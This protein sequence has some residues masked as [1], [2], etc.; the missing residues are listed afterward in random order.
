MR[1]IHKIPKYLLLFLVFIIFF[2]PASAFSQEKPIAKLADFSGTVLIKSQGSWGVKPVKDLPL[3]SM[4]KLVTRV[5]NATIVFNDGGTINIKNNTNLLINEQEKK[6]GLVTIIERHIMLFLG[7]LNFKTGKSGKSNVE[8][9][10]ETTRA[11]IGIRGTAGILSIGADGKTYIYFS[12]GEAKYILGDF[13]RGIAKDVQAYLA[14]QNPGQRAT[15]V[16][17]AATDQVTRTEKMVAAGKM[18][19]SQLDLAKAIAKE[20]SA[21]EM[22]TLGESMLSSPDKKRVE[23]AKEQIL[24]AK[25]T[26]KEAKK[27]QKNAIKNGADPAFKGFTG[28]NPGFD[29]PS[30]KS[31]QG[32]KS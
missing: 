12:E 26:I 16:A 13:I 1:F 7:K 25:E 27:E 8:T 17:K 11:V 9:R 3:Y 20:T 18:P 21:L 2:I 19:P 14:D 24:K 5:G 30:D 10:F 29:V 32:S 23:W 31:D 15:L 4:D 22:L 28:E 6:K